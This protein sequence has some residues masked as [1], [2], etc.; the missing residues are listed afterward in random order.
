[1]FEHPWSCFV[2][3]VYQAYKRRREREKER[4]RERERDEMRKKERERERERV[5]SIFINFSY[6]TKAR[7][8]ILKNRW[9][10]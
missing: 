5:Y 4:E 3:C 10:R 2:C 9:N 8:N 1:M 6:A 7:T